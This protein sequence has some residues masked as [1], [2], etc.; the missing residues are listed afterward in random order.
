MAVRAWAE[1]MELVDG[2]LFDAESYDRSELLAGSFTRESGYYV[3]VRGAGAL[4][5]PAPARLVGPYRSAELA[6][7]LANELRRVRLGW[8]PP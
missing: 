7:A 4:G 3:M 5:H 8:S 6:D 2:R 1:V